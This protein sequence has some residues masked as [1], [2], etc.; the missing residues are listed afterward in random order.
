MLKIKIIVVD[1]TRAPFL[2]QGEDFYLDR[3]RRY[4]RTEWVVVKPVR[5]TKAMGKSQVL[6]REG[7]LIDKRLLARDHV[8]ALDRAGTAYDSEGL[9]GRIKKLALTQNRLAFIIGG[10]LGLSKRILGR[11]DEVLGLSS[12]TLTHEMSRLVLLE[13]L[14]RAFTIINNEKYHK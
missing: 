9:A 10:V 1:R 3:L 12:L 11:A 13:Q 4:A 6:V 8:I 2:K 7:E 5:A 14:Y